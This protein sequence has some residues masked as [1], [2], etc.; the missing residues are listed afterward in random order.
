MARNWHKLIELNDVDMVFIETLLLSED[1]SNRSISNSLLT[2]K[3]LSARCL[4]CLCLTVQFFVRLREFKLPIWPLRVLQWRQIVGS[5][6]DSWVKKVTSYGLR[7]TSFQFSSVVD[8]FILHQYEVVNSV[9]GIRST[10]IKW[11]IEQARTISILQNSYRLKR[12]F[13]HEFGSLYS[14]VKSHYGIAWKSFY[15]LNLSYD[16][17]RMNLQIMANLNPITL[18]VKPAFYV[19]VSVHHNSIIYKEPTR[20]NFGSIV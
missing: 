20:C 10:G 19:W 7:N 9:N 15:S 16:N 5:L 8:K 4:L 2:K 11:G 18:S 12:K 14:G 6:G 13:S 1:T 17:Y 3:P